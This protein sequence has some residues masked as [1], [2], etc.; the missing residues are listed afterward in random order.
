MIFEHNPLFLEA[1]RGE[2]FCAERK[3]IT[4]HTRNPRQLTPSKSLGEKIL[5]KEIK[6]REKQGFRKKGE[7]GGGEKEI[8][9]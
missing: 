7:C 4:Q 6:K 9:Q 1:E 2:K 8:C 5:E 3:K